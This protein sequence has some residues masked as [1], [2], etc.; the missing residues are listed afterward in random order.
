MGTYGIGPIG[1]IGNQQLIWRGQSHTAILK[2]TPWVAMDIG[3]YLDTHP[4]W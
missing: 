3:P 1:S 4:S 2:E